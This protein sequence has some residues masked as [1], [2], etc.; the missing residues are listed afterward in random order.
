MREHEGNK[1]LACFEDSS[2][3][4]RQPLVGLGLLKKLC[5]FVSVEGDILPI[6]DP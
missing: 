2:S 6:L 5:P 4:A 3:L 1:L